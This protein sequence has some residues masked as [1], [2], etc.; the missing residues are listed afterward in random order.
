ML[1]KRIYKMSKRSLFFISIC[2][3]A[4]M[5]WP[6][7]S[8]AQA[9]GMEGLQSVAEKILQNRQ[10]NMQAL[11]AYSW[12]QRTEVIKDGEVMSTKLELV[13]Y[14]SN[15]YEQRS[16]LTE[17]KPKQ[18]KRIAGRVQKKKM[19]EM[20]EWG[21][22]VKS[23]L[24]QYTLPD[25]ASLNNF[26]GKASINPTDEPG[27]TMLNSNN[28]IQPG[29]RMTMYINERDKKVQ[30]TTVFTNYEKDSVLVEIIHGQLPE[31][32]NYIKEMKLDISTKEIQLKVE[33]FN[34]IRN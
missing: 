22:N 23:L 28:V 18:K 12:N 30:K 31:S 19:G 9:P 16:T 34:Y 27:Q 1:Y 2:L 17:Q 20:Q 3:L 10:R 25:V 21:A 32:I 8:A 24:M 11:K 5:I 14:D 6:V 13:R 29:D 15:G 33:N 4:S 7:T 26:L